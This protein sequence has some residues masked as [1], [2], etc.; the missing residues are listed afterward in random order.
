MLWRRSITNDRHVAGLFA[1]HRLIERLLQLLLA[2]PLQQEHLGGDVGRIL[3]PGT[4]N[5]MTSYIY[6]VTFTSWKN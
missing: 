4:I 5:S 2:A 6:D 3:P 1:S